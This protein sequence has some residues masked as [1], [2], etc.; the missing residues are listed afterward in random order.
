MIRDFTLLLI[1]IF[2]ACQVYAQERPPV[3]VTVTKVSKIP[4]CTRIEALGT[5]LANESVTITANTSEK[6]TGIL[7]SDTQKVNAGDVLVELDFGEE[8]SRLNSLKAQLIAKQPS[9]E[10]AQVLVDQNFTTK[11]SLESRQADLEQLQGEIKAIEEQIKD[12]IIKAP[13]SGIVDFRDISVGTLVRPGDVITRL[14]DISRI[15]VNFEIPSLFLTQV[16]PGQKVLGHV[17]AYPDQEFTGEI[18]AISPQV[19]TVTRTVRVR[20]IFPNEKE[21]L[22]P[23][24][25]MKITIIANRR[26]TL[27][28]PEA[29]IKQKGN[30]HFL[31]ILQKDGEKS[32]AVLQKV[33]IGERLPGVTEIIEGVSSTDTIIDRGNV[34]LEH[35]QPVTIAESGVHEPVDIDSFRC[36]SPS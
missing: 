6:V 23:G 5:T 4:L 28:V 13:F 21:L 36:E 24:L 16:K 27:V 26:E 31:H 10:R 11:A 25:L 2:S 18:V 19:N 8:K 34:S 22:K 20:A 29:S 1:L 12:R 3:S 15:K 9:L 14:Y 30:D 7:F 32:F 17:E 33:S 35:K